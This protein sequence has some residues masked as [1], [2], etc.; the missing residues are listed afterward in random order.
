MKIAMII[1]YFTPENGD[2]PELFPYWQI[3]AS[4]NK[5]IDFY[6]VTNIDTDRYVAYP[7][8]HFISMSHEYF[9]NKIE[10]MLEFKVN[11]GFYKIGEY[12][13][14]LGLIFEETLK[15]YDYWGYT[16]FDLVYGNILKFVEPYLD[17]KSP[18]IGTFGHFRLIKNEK[19]INE[20]AIIPLK[21]NSLLSIKDAYQA[22]VCTHFDEVQGM[23]VRYYIDKIAV[24]SLYNVIA[25]IDQKYSFFKIFGRKGK[26]LFYWNEN[27]LIGKS[28]KGETMEFLYAHF[29]KRS[30]NIP[31]V[32]N[33]ITSFSI[34]PNELTIGENIVDFNSQTVFYT[35]KNR[36]KYKNKN[37]KERK[38]ISR[39]LK[40]KIKNTSEFCIDKGLFQ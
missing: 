31:K 1:P 30:L 28:N 11:R 33:E 25:D 29:Q 16:E 26:W 36:I 13:P 37:L 14:L 40:N 7:N 2:F 3:T 21:Q 18:V 35:I 15:N 6:V 19:K 10:K 34:I 5:K 17:K 22:E 8:I 27:G 9:I 4:Y 20:I 23:G 32:N 39:E 24:H 12:R 38:L